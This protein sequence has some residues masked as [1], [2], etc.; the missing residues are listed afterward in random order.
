MSGPQLA[1]WSGY[2]S[3]ASL[4]L[5]FLNTLKLA[6]ISSLIQRDR[7]RIADTIKPFDAYT[8][9]RDLM[10]FLQRNDHRLLLGEAERIQLAQILQGLAATTECLR[11]YFRN[12]YDLR[13]VQNNVYID[14]GKLFQRKSDP[15]IALE[16]YE[17]GFH[18]ASTVPDLVDAKTCLQGMYFCYALLKDYGGMAFVEE[19]ALQ[20]ELSLQPRGTTLRRLFPQTL[21]ILAS[22][23]KLLTWRFSRKP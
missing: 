10:E 6:K 21:T 13:T 19:L 23:V 3:I 8:N 16:F 7:D 12:T 22:K 11:S 15:Q 17:K 2:A 5:V 1:L 9:I 18:R 20:M 4:V 14:A